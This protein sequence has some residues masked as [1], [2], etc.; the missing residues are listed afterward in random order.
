MSILPHYFGV[1]DHKCIIVNFLREIFFRLQT[2]PI[3]KAK[4]H[5]LSLSQPQSVKNYIQKAEQLLTYHKIDQKIN[6]I[7][8]DWP[9]LT[10]LKK[11]N[12]LNKIDTQIMELLLVSEKKCRSLRVGAVSFSPDLLRVGLK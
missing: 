1:G 7:K 4:M 11:E 8:R 6:L 9:H 10:Q 12:Q 5:R 2:I 3:V